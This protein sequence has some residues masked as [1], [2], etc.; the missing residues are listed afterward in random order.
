MRRDQVP[1]GQA[2]RK[3]N[4]FRPPTPHALVV[5]AAL[6]PVLGPSMARAET[7]TFGYLLAWGH[8]TLAEAE[9]SYR[10]SGASY[11]LMGQGRTRGILELFFPWQGRART[12]GLLN[13]TARRSL[14]HQHE[15]VWK[16][17]TRWTRVEWDGAAAPRTEAH[18]PPDPE[19]VT[20][21]P[22]ASTVGTSD[23]FTALLSVLDRLPATGRC[24]A[25]ASVWDGRRRYDLSVSHLGEKTLVA[26]RPWAYE[27][28]AIGC[29]LSY[30]RIGGFW[31]ERP[32]WRDPDEDAPGRRVVWV[33]E[34]A[35]EQWVVVRAEMETR[36]GTVVG[37]LLPEGGLESEDEDAPT[38]K[39]A[40]SE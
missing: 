32:D 28:P 30:E 11:H 1:S 13:G 20:P 18:P 15:G 10:Q 2:P 26:D 21:V 31:R 27:G 3:A 38:T 40:L 6:L 36:Y 24:E 14:V 12:E 34:F 23:P 37:R 16:E 25:E 33:A 29:A 4:G 39:A 17:K 7:Q 35:P 9:V 22:E 5:L 19:K 8:L